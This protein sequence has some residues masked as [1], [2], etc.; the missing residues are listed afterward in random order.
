MLRWPILAAL[1]R[2]VPPSCTQHQQRAI[3]NL[4]ENAQKHKEAKFQ[5]LS[6]R[7]RLR[8]R[9]KIASKL[10]QIRI[11]NLIR[12]EPLRYFVGGGSASMTRDNGNY[13]VQP[14]KKSRNSRLLVVTSSGRSNVAP[15]SISSS[16]TPMWPLSAARLRGVSPAIYAETNTARLETPSG[17]QKQCKAKRYVWH[18]TALL[19]NVQYCAEWATCAAA[20]TNSCN[21]QQNMEGH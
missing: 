3:G 8:N 4:A 10:A 5:G 7:S 17:K 9:S 14:A 11:Q 15:C 1:C 19:G 6:V 2:P 20:A 13:A 12:L 16:T 21:V 18:C